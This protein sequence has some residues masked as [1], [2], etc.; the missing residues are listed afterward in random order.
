MIACS[1]PQLEQIAKQPARGL[2]NDD[3]VR[4]GDALETCGS[5]VKSLAARG[6]KAWGKAGD[7]ADPAPLKA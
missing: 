5:A 2:R 1:M 6:P 7:I 4:L 3:R